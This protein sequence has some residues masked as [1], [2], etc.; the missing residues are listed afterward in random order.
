VHDDP[1]FAP[2]TL[3]EA[4]DSFGES[5][6]PGSRL[7]AGDRVDR[8]VVETLLGEG[9]VASVYRVRHRA[10]DSRHALKVLHT[11]GSDITERLLAEGRV[12]VRLRH[13]N[14]VQVQDALEAKG[15][16]ALLMEWVDG[17]TLAQRLVDGRLSVDEA[18]RIFRAVVAGVGHAHREGVVHRDL[19][20]ANVLLA[21][22]GATPKVGDFGI[23]K[24]L[25]GSEGLM[26]TATGRFLGTPAYMAPEQIRDPRGVDARA[27]I[28]ALGVMLYELVCGRRPF[29]GEDVL[30]L[31]NAVNES[32][33]DDPQTLSPELPLP[34][35][36]VIKGC[37]KASPA[38][39]LPSCEAILAL[40]DDAP[41][42]PPRA[43]TARVWS[44]GRV[45][46]I[47]AALVV[48]VGAGWSIGAS[49]D[50]G[51]RQLQVAGWE[52]ADKEPGEALALLRHAARQSRNPEAVLD[53]TTVDRLVA[54]GAGVRVIRPG[55][56]VVGL[57]VHG[58]S[59][60]AAAGL[61]GGDIALFDTTTG[62]ELRRRSGGVGRV[63]K[64]V[65]F[66][67]AGDRLTLRA[68]LGAGR[69]QA[70]SPGRVL[71]A[72]TGEVLHT[73]AHGDATLGLTLSADGRFAATAGAS[74]ESSVALWDARTGAPLGRQTFE[75]VVRHSSLT[76]D[77][78]GTRLALTELI[79]HGPEDWEVWTRILTTPDLAPGPSIRLSSGTEPR[80]LRFIGEGARL[81]YGE[82]FQVG[83]IS[84]AEGREEA[85]VQ[86]DIG[87][88]LETSPRGDR[89]VHRQGA[90][91]L[92][93]RLPSLD[94]I[95]YLDTEGSPA[96]QATFSADG[97]FVAVATHA[98]VVYVFETVTGRR[99][100]RLAGHDSLVLAARFLDP[101]GAQLLTGS[102][103]GSMRLWQRAVPGSTALSVLREAE[104]A[105][106]LQLLAHPGRHA[107]VRGP[108][109][110]L[111]GG[112]PSFSW[113]A[114]RAL[115]S[116][117][118]SSTDGERL[119]V[120][121]GGDDNT[122]L[123]D[124]SQSP[125]TILARLP[126]MQQHVCAL[127]PDGDVAVRVHRT[128]GISTWTEDDGAIR[129]ATGAPEHIQD[130]ALAPDGRLALGG[131]K[132]GELFV[133]D[134]RDPG[135]VRPLR[136]AD[137]GWSSFGFSGDGQA[138]IAA[139]WQG[140]VAI[141]TRGGEL[142]AELVG[143]T[144]GVLKAR[145]SHDASVAV[146]GSWD[147]TA[148][149]W[150]GRTGR[151]LHVLPHPT[152]DVTAL[153]L[154]LDER[155]LWTGSKD[156]KVRVW[157]VKSGR[158]LAVHDGHTGP[159]RQLQALAD[160]TARSVCTGRS[161][162]TWPAPPTGDVDASL[163]AGSLTNFRVCAGTDRVVPVVPFPPA[164]STLAPEE[165]CE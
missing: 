40:L 153:A 160:G 73:Y 25:T 11:L 123:F 140:E 107:L 44:R 135:S 42:R 32:R 75:G 70:P 58:S 91:L 143:H 63:L 165:A 45:A 148:R 43:P 156:H 72:H 36:R 37:L 6:S 20:P 83:V 5:G 111:A 100:R 28:F 97:A 125:P 119:L 2:R 10:L 74:G 27:D 14:I 163:V 132:E 149:I 152:G 19:K 17:Q 129:T 71:N 99:V 114:P 54:R 138:L 137:D 59:D 56:Q 155:T 38:E 77:A 1:Q 3:D 157:D 122:L 65:Q 26:T 12:Q 124:L 133:F 29:V 89:L 104:S 68:W 46:A 30:S 151:L 98:S 60:R 94:P 9:G 79:A 82:A 121:G 159:V 109:V 147:R 93:R 134:P 8:Y 92:L 145:L 62:L 136:S 61:L 76:F 144:D 80:Q 35:V 110:E 34:V 48:A 53:M 113:E 39:R 101:A 88:L 31:L 162:I 49:D 51:A 7:I 41:L 154:S 118:Q 15:S 33:Y 95:S 126:G 103:D 116:C 158:L 87:R 47:S 142:R 18:E 115:L 64:F 13:P 130:L 84:V 150:D 23:A 4:P 24:H 105:G 128:G 67:P 55:D 141:W 120:S 96:E 161:L 16:P 69:G 112:G 146:T 139:T 78:T 90:D 81:V 106:T 21:D 131:T 108:H 102:R 117:V 85:T 127:S 164:E 57:D 86:A 52:R 22:D 50:G 66:D